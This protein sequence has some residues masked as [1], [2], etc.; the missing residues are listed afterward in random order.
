MTDAARPSR[1]QVLMEAQT[2]LRA[3]PL[4]ITGGA[5]QAWQAYVAAVRH[6]RDLVALLTLPPDPL[7]APQEAWEA[8]KRYAPVLITRY[9]AD[10]SVR[11]DLRFDEHP[12]GGYMESAAVDRARLAQHVQHQQEVRELKDACDFEQAQALMY[13]EK[14]EAAESELSRLRAHLHVL[15]QELA[16]QRT[17][18]QVVLPSERPPVL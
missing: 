7:P 5:G 18:V 2:W 6:I 3:Y 4:A 15:E 16:F 10:D 11:P 1:E 12:E 17:T 14:W 13:M 8:V 9:E